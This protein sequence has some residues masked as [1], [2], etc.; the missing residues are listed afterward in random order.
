M[1]ID[2]SD[3]CLS[4]GHSSVAQHLQLKPGT[5]GLMFPG[6]AQLSPVMESWAGP[7]NK[8]RFDSW[9]LPTLSLLLH[10]IATCLHLQGLGTSE[11]FIIVKSPQHG[12]VIKRDNQLEF[13]WGIYKLFWLYATCVLLFC[14]GLWA[15][16]LR[17]WL[18][19]RQVLSWFPEFYSSLSLPSV[20]N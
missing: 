12:S 10:S 11:G 6:P 1:H 18:V 9:W 5:L 13:G 4:G 8:A 17:I 15:Q 20:L 2:D 14:H 19:F 7:G 3:W 16:W